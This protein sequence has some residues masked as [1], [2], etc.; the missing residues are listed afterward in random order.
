M[1]LEEPI[2]VQPEADLTTAS[3]ASFLNQFKLAT[4]LSV[5]KQSFFEAEVFRSQNIESRWIRNEALYLGKVPQK[6]WQGTSVPRSSVSFSLVADQV[7][8]ALPMIL[9]A[10]MSQPDWFEVLPKNGTTLPEALQI[11]DQLLYQLENPGEGNKPFKAE[12]EQIVK[13]MLVKG[14]GYVTLEYNPATKYIKPS[15]RDIRDI[16]ID[17]GCSDPLNIDA[18]RFIILR[19]MKTVDEVRS[20]RELPSMNVPSDE[21][22]AHLS[23]SGSQR[24]A[25][26]LK[27]QQAQMTGSSETPATQNLIPDAAGNRLEVLTYYSKKQIVMTLG[28]EWVL[29]SETNPFGFFPAASCVCTVVN[30]Q[31]Y[32]QSIADRQAD[33]QG[34]IAGLINGHL[35]EVALSINPPRGQGSSAS[36]ADASSKYL[37]PGQVW[38]L[39]NPKTDLNFFT[40]SGVTQN[41]FQSIDFLIRT[42]DSRTGFDT[43]AGKFKP[44]NANRTLGG[45]QMQ[46]AGGF[47]RISLLVQHVEDMLVQMLQKMLRMT[48]VIAG[49]GV[50]MPAKV[51]DRQSYLVNSSVLGKPVNVCIRASSQMLTRD[52]LMGILP[53]ITQFYTQPNF[54]QGLAEADMKL[55]W[56]EMFRFVQQATGVEKQFDFV[57]PL[58]P[59]EK[60]ARQQPPP[61]VLMQAQ[62][63]ERS[64]QVRLQLGQMKSQTELQ[65]A[66][67]AKQPDP[68]EAMREQQKMNL[69]REKAL[70]EAE[71][72]A[73]KLEFEAQMQALKLQSEQAKMAIA[74][75]KAQ[76]DQVIAQTKAQTDLRVNELQ[77]F[78]AVQQGEQA[79]QQQ[80][81]TAAQSNRHA[82]EAHKTK[83]KMQEAGP[84]DSKARSK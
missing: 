42:G 83:L 9:Q 59:E 27:Q 49:S 67:I 6:Y 46:Q 53:V 21:Q 32:G 45:M 2:P 73:Q 1:A 80:E 35:D 47:T 41:V 39:K 84:P 61:E 77:G 51:N 22:L 66:A 38:S 60:Q 37:H 58:T 44:G 10:L 7:E 64:D 69:E 50:F 14:N 52:K 68:S 65:K 16:Y 48:S 36:G 24:R 26:Q 13:D 74:A 28:T 4:A 33:L 5:V 81:A 25:E 71:L 76:L 17:P 12:L 78:Q 29:F 57:V 55:N 82:E 63:A 15:F 31:H 79:L 56:P 43:A 30:G 3:I 62:Q 19:D 8:A 72:Q 20:W 75:Q 11:R 23:K 70:M 40:P 34:T 18:A 54:Q